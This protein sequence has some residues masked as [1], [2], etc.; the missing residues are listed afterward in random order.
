MLKSF[1]NQFLNT[2]RTFVRLIQSI[3]YQ[4]GNRPKNERL[5]QLIKITHHI[6]TRDT[7]G[8]DLSRWS[9]TIP[10]LYHYEPRDV[11][12]KVFTSATGTDKTSLKNL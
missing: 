8:L 7:S 1:R 3:N 2:E 4:L 12:V 11:L 10:I 9:R 5:R 6:S